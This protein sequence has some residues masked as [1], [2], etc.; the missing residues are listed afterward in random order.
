MKKIL[1]AG[2]AAAAFCGA[3]AIA[4][5]MPIKAPVYKATPAPYDPWTGCYIGA[6]TG[7]AW[8]EKTSFVFGAADEG[9]HTASGWAY[10]GQIGCDYQFNN[11]WVIGIQGMF[12]G[13]AAKGSNTLPLFPTETWSS[14]VRFFGTADVRLGYLLNPMTLL[15]GKAGLGWIDTSYTFTNG[16]STSASNTRSGFNAGVGV[17][18]MFAP[19]W[20]FFLEYDHTFLSGT[21]SVT[22]PG[23]GLGP[24][25]ANIHQAGLDTV[26]VGIDYRFG[27]R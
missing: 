10:G 20:D 3:P 13:A 26:L 17:A 22:F 19:H 16:P 5:D 1:M 15:Y 25:S 24:F 8:A 11:N 2:I 27:G 7:G 14:K 21:N 4:T 18:W 6:N 9:N 12:D 23:I